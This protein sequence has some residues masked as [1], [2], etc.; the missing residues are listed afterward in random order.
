MPLE[1]RAVFDPLDGWVVVDRSDQ[2]LYDASSGAMS[3]QEADDL[4]WGF[5]QG[6][7]ND[8]EAL[9]ML[10]ERYGRRPPYLDESV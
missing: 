9:R 3:Q 2:S 5:N 10:M 7:K 6:A 1:Y 8:A 4:A